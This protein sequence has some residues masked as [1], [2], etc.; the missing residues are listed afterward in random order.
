MSET[1]QNKTTSSPA[2][3]KSFMTAGPTL[4]YSHTNVLW[5][6]GL[7]ILVFL[8]VCLFWKN[9]MPVGSEKE[10][11]GI[12]D[13]K[14]IYDILV[15]RLG[16]IVIEP[17]S[18]YEYPWYIVILGILIGLLAVVPVLVSQLL[19]FRF[20]IPLILSVMFIAQLYFFGFLVLVSCAA[21]ACRPLR[22]RSRYV[23]L[24]LCMAPQLVYWAVWGGYPTADPVRWGFSFAPWIYAWLSGLFMAA[25]VLGIGHFTRYKPGLTWLTCL[26]FLGIAFGIFQQ[27][28]GFAELDYHRYVADN[29]PEGVVEFHEHS[30]SDVLDSVL[31]DNL[32]RSRFEGVFYPRESVEL[33][34]KL[35]EE[36]QDFLAYHNLWPEWFRRKMPVEFQYQQKRG[37]LL[38]DYNKFIERWPGNEKRMPIVLYYK[39]ILSELHPD[40]RL[41]T[42][43]GLLRFY[44]DHPFKDNVLKWQE[45]LDEFT[46]A[47]ESIEARWRL[48]VDLARR[49][50]FEKAGE[51]CQMAKLMIDK[52]EGE[53]ED[54][55]PDK[56][57]SIFAAFQKPPETVITSFKLNDL[58]F[59]FQK[60]QSLLSAENMGPDQQSK[61]R[62]AEF[63]SLNPYDL[64][65][66]IRLDG[67]LDQ[68][69]R[70]DGLRDNIML[71]KIKLLDDLDQRAKMLSQL[72]RTYPRRDTAGEAKYEL[73]S[74]KI[75]LWKQSDLPEPQKQDL[76]DEAREILSEMIEQDSE[77]HYARQ[78]EAALQTLSPIMP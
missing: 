48:A 73:G 33:K 15:F 55:Q 36:V 52:V 65:Y 8:L 53:L 68:M 76:L 60:L 3:A 13:F 42:D 49:L 64:N 44:D 38:S 27:Q 4:H 29:D 66:G 22:F 26:L 35:E 59:R 32:L 19:S 77:C 56:A 57:D 51:Y 7:S 43:R 45:L 20:S 40:V 21:V 61:E 17:I 70:G 39:A 62:L 2:P 34:Q 14:D 78:A 25:I 69:S 28:I 12:F 46:D 23:S 71:E 74:A 5:F 11:S 63:L 75:Q 18:I 47:P 58:S 30:I 50:K 31:E 6:W 16:T 67:M 1:H 9:L 41:I 24:A 10:V 72:I 54:V 37:Q